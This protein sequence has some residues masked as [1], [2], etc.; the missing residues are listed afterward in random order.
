MKKYISIHF[1]VLLVLSLLALIQTVPVYAK[2]ITVCAQT[3]PGCDQA[4]GD[5]IQKAVD[6]TTDG[7]TVLIKTGTYTSDLNKPCFVDLGSKKLTIEGEGNPI[8]AWNGTVLYGEG[9]SKPDIYPNRAGICSENG[10]VTIRNI[11]I[12]EFQGGGLNFTNSR[13]VL[14]SSVIDTNDAGGVALHNSSALIVNNIFLND[15]N[16]SGQQPIKAINN[17]INGKA[18]DGNCNEDVGPLDFINNVVEDPELTIGLGW[19]TGNC[20][21][22]AAQ[23]STKNITYNLFWKD[24][25]PCYTNHEFCDFTQP[26]NAKHNLNADPMLKK[27]APDA[28]GWAPFGDGNFDPAAGSPILGAGDPQIPNANNELGAYGG[29]CVQYQSATCTQFIQTNTPPLPQA[30]QP[31]AQPPGNNPPGNNPPNGTTQNT[32]P[33]QIINPQD[34]KFGVLPALI[35]TS[36]FAGNIQI[37]HMTSGQT[38]S[39]TIIGMNLTVYIVLAVVF[40]MIFHFAIGIGGEFDLFI[41]I[42]FFAFGGFMGGLFHSYEGGLVFSI[43]LSLIFF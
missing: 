1:V 5:G 39:N 34:L 17:T 32:K 28:R 18:I 23:Y 11:H 24:N 9:H 16:R 35:P 43:I 21:D 12:R 30:A 15:I 4:G 25:H 19:I 41:M 10:D 31:P 3:G 42:G 38:W 22:K 6:Q 2:T 40:I 29:P 37:P 33:P 8:G 14:Y 36:Y 26:N 7:D 27:P 13:L 20:P